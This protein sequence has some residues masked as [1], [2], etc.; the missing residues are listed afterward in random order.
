MEIGQA[1]EIKKLYFSY[2]HIHIKETTMT[3]YKDT[4]TAGRC[5]HNRGRQGTVVVVK[6]FKVEASK[7]SYSSKQRAQ[8]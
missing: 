7:S 8:I 1:N 5:H 4:T 3:G 2:Y 6:D